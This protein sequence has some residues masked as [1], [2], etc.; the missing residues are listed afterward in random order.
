MIPFEVSEVGSTD[1]DAE[2]YAITNV[3]EYAFKKYMFGPKS[4]L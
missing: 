3:D 1:A 4:V 2:M